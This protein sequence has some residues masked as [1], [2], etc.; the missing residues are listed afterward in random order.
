MGYNKKIV[1]IG[2]SHMLLHMIFKVLIIKMSN[3]VIILMW[4]VIVMVS[5]N[6]VF[7]LFSGMT[8]R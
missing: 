7:L 1:N 8:M 2:R 5:L 3:Y 6:T 4:S